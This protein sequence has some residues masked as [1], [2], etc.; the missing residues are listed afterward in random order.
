MRMHFV[1]PDLISPTN[2]I[3]VAL[4][5]AGGTGSQMLTCLARMN[6]S[7][8]ALGHA[9]LRVTL[10]DDDRVEESNL[11]RQLF[12]ESELGLYKAVAL[13]NRVNRFFGTG[14]RAQTKRFQDVK[15]LNADIFIS[16]VDNVQ[17][18]LDLAEL[19]SKKYGTWLNRV[20][21]KYWID[22]GNGKS[23]G[24]VILSTI[25]EIK[26]P[27]SKKFEPVAALP[28]VTEEFAGLLQKSE[29][30]D[31]TPSC[32]LA[33]A[34]EKQDLFINSCLAQMGSSLLWSMFRKGMIQ[35]RGF[36]LNLENFRSAPILV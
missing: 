25:G 5:G 27:K 19:L 16:C 33:E 9:G 6:H 35:E 32:S 26:Q 14:W 17:T 34:L 8:I 11:S 29:V 13:I 20:G 12:A 36:F 22:F 23:S 28:F 18:R 21:E 1:S 15:K 31:D 3:E 2:P 4:I 10:I 24:Q 30:E 7:L